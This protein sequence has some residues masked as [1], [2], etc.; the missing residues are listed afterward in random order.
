MLFIWDM[1]TRGAA[2]LATSLRDHWE[3]A[4]LFRDLATLR[5]DADVLG[6]VDELQ[7]ERTNE[8]FRASLR[9]T[10]CAGTGGAGSPARPVTE[11]NPLQ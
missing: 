3:D 8:I 4:L 10:G 5:T 11:H 7:M 9:A 2:G 6:D 1:R